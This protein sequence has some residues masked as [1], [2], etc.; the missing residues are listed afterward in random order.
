MNVAS[1]RIQVDEIWSFVGAKAKSLRAEERG[2]FGRGDVWTYVALD[3]DSKLVVSYFIGPRDSEAATAF[4]EDVRSRLTDRVQL[5]SDGHSMY[6]AA[7]ENA[8]GADVD[9]AQIIKHYGTAAEG[10]TRYSPAFC[11]GVETR[12]ITGTPDLHH[13]NTSYVERQNLTMRMHMRR[14]TRLTNAFSKKIEQHAAAISLHFA[15]INFVRIHQTLRVTPAMAA[16]RATRPW[17]VENQIALLP[18][19]QNAGGRPRREKTN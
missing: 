2:T 6:L 16:G 10:E 15:Y 18:P 19:V 7:V 1:K 3:A 13:I 17:T 5:G 12:L 8:F 4:L 14:F 11:T 9:F